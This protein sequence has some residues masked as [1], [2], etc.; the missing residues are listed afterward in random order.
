MQV[1][2]V[3]FQ[4][5]EG[6]NSFWSVAIF[7]TCNALRIIDPVAGNLSGLPSD[8]LQC[9]FSSCTK[10][11]TALGIKCRPTTMN[12]PSHLLNLSAFTFAAVHHEHRITFDHHTFQDLL[13]LEE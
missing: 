9:L 3:S 4:N 7:H 6:G 8:Q 1:S 2:G 5:H 12:A 10:L 11:A 13:C